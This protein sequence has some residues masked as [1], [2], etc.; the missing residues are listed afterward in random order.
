MTKIPRVLV[1]TGTPGVG[2]TRVAT[3]LRDRLGGH[4][5]SLSEIVT[6]ENLQLAV[7][8]ARDTVVADVPQLTE[9]V[10]RIISEASG[11]VVVEGHYA[12]DV[13]SPDVVTYVFVLRVA[14]DKLRQRLL[15]R[16]YPEGKVRENVAAEVLDVCLVDAV[17][18]YGEAKVDE[19]DGT[20]LSVQE[21]VDEILKVV[22]GHRTTTRGAVDWLGRLEAE[23]RLDELAAYL[24]W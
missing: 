18:R 21:V 2:K 8:V 20:S 1:V 19:I 22:D 10:H 4:Y 16:G 12:P 3:T 9:L 5:L 6:R 17:A 11:D 24:E 7:D 13:V 23:D 15:E 14:P